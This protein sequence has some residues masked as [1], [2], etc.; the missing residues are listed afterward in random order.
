MKTINQVRS[1]ILLTSALAVAGSALAMKTP[2]IALAAAAGKSSQPVQREE[3]VPGL[4]IKPRA[5]GGEQMAAALAN[6]DTAAMSRL[7]GAKLSAFRKMS[8]GAHVV[9][10]AKPVPLSEARAM[11]VRMMQNGSV[12]MAEPD[13]IMRPLFT[14]ND[15]RYATEQWHYQAPSRSNLGG[16]NLPK[17]WDVTKG[18][19]SVVVAVL[20][21]GIR[22]HE[23]IDSTAVLPGYDFIT[24][25]SSKA[26]P[27]A[28]DGNGRD[29]DATDP[30]DY[31]TTED[32][33]YDPED[34]SQNNSSW[35]GTH[36]AGTIIASMS[37]Q[38]GGTGIAPNVKVL[39]VRV[40]GTCGGLVSDIIDGMY[41][42]V[43]RGS[44]ANS[45]PA[46][47]LNMSLGGTP[48]PCSKS[49]QDAV[50]VVTAEG[51]V[52]VAATGNENTIDVLQPANCNGV[53]AVTAHSIDADKAEYATIGPQTS[54][55]A[56]G[57]GCSETSFIRGNC[58]VGNS[59]SVLSTVNAGTTIPSNDT[60]AYAAYAGTSMAVSHVSGVAALL[61]SRNASLT[62]SRVKS[63]LQTYARPFPA[64]SVCVTD[65]AYANQCGAGLL[66]AQAAVAAANPVSGPPQLVLVTPDSV[67]GP[68]TQV[69]LTATAIPSPTNTLASY[70]WVQLTGQPVA[71]NNANT[72]TAS[73]T[74]PA[75][76]TLSF[77]VTAT[78]SAGR[79]SVATV[80]VRVNSPP[81]AAVVPAQSVPAGQTLNVNLPAT[82]ADG[83]AITYTLLSGPDGPTLDPLTGLLTWNVGAPVGPYLL[84]YA[85]SDQDGSTQGSVT[86]NV[87]QAKSGGGG[88]MEGGILIAFAAMAAAR[89]IQRARKPAEHARSR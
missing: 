37:N 34:P 83:D 54:L 82:D 1:A 24:N 32:F 35:H 71:L 23:D 11:A 62:P 78:D 70:Q 57:G 89:R 16:A 4:M 77:Q 36:V 74:A 85:V 45:T 7:V 48:G 38:V 63:L 25:F 26:A 28:N 72:Q 42:A 27:R 84:T 50:D 15:P 13:R 41:W 55:S 39:P 31:V 20:D 18:N 87:T 2:D 46:R 73:F 64:T 12:E 10:L 51:A 40:L 58:R 21:T 53:I 76:G 60:S 44:P 30:G 29:P 75:T 68:M 81:V 80:I 88:S 47:V 33:C 56:P 22:P 49:L 61:F 43:G 69:A 6:R 52:I 66:D 14:P 65:P 9:R 79:S 86:V 19:P 5:R 8:S 3:M 17:A 67:V 59:V